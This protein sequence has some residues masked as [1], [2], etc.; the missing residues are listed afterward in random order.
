MIQ[1]AKRSRESSIQT[2]VASGTECLEGCRAEVCFR[3]WCT[4][5]PPYRSKHARLILVLRGVP[6]LDVTPESPISWDSRYSYPLSAFTNAHDS[7]PLGETRGMA[8][9][10]VLER[11]NNSQACFAAH[12]HHA[13]WRPSS[14]RSQFGPASMGECCYDVQRG[15]EVDKPYCETS[16]VLPLS[17]LVRSDCS[18]A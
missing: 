7:L 9:P 15:G 11:S 3:G 5:K 4:L 13:P 14:S 10:H 6:S 18:L 2:A 17:P 8:V 12:P 1:S 16:L